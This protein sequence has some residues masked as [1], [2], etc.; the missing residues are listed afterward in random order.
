MATTKIL[1]LQINEPEPFAELVCQLFEV[2]SEK[3]EDLACFLHLIEHQEDD[4]L[5]YYIVLKAKLDPQNSYHLVPLV[6]NLTP[7]DVPMTKK[8]FLKAFDLVFSTKLHKSPFG[9]SKSSRAIKEQV[10]ELRAA[11]KS[12]LASRDKEIAKNFE[13]LTEF[14]G[15]GQ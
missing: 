3:Q 7:D 1:L 14:F 4:L 5:L 15:S 11:F 2:L 13:Q 12:D 8:N 6:Q 10:K 9:Y